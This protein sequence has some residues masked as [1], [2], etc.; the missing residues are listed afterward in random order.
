VVVTGATGHLGRYVVDEL[1]RTGHDVVAV[2]RRGQLPDRPFGAPAPATETSVHS[3]AADLTDDRAVDVLAA[4]L[5]GASGLV[6]LAA[7]HPPATAASTAADRRALIE[8]NVLGTQRVL[9]AVRAAGG[10]P[11]VVYA[12]TF[13]VYGAPPR[14]G[15]VDEDCPPSPVTDYG[16]TKL[17]GEDHLFAFA[18]EEGVR[19]LALRLPAIYGP[20]ERVSRALPNFLR[21]V[22][23]GDRPVVQGDGRD[24][25]DQVHGRDAAWAFVEALQ[26]G[27]G[28]A[29]NVSDG[30]PHTILELAE[31][32]LRVAGMTGGPERRPAAKPPL[33]FHMNIDKARRDL[34]FRPAISLESGMAQQLAWLRTAAPADS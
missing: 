33:D 18:A 8:G 11:V 19:T 29:Y 17:A 1:A 9:D 3:C 30:A 31:T 27:P 6:H 2:S 16:A 5:S 28:G 26:R 10:V 14:P 20:G 15:P 34:G 12:S 21:A 13:E 24:R 7:W 25:R 22:A 23:R 4:A 32:A